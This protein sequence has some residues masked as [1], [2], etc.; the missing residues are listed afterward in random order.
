MLS[1]F[2]VELIHVSNPRADYVYSSYTTITPATVNEK[3]HCNDS[4][5]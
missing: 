5:S 3:K 4:N 1:K 2:K